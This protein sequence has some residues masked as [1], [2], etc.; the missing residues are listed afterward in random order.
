M[1]LSPQP[2]L[3]L[4]VVPLFETIA[5]LR[6]CAKIIDALL[7]MPRYRQLLADRGDVQEVM[8]GYSDSNKDG[9]YLTSSWELYQAAVALVRVGRARHK[10]TLV[11]RPRRHGRPRWRAEL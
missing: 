1:Q 5:S 3:A 2:R 11:S 7:S 9:G 10:V 8:L 6:D 4:N